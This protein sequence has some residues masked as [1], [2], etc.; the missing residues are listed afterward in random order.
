MLKSVYRCRCRS[1]VSAGSNPYAAVVDGEFI[2]VGEDGEGELGGPCVASELE[3]GVGVAVDVDGGLFCFDEEFSCAADSEAVVGG[4]C[5]GADFDGVFVDDVFVCFC[6]SGGVVYVPAESDEEWV[7]ELSS[8][9]GFV[10]SAGFV[11]VGV[12]CEALDEVDD[13][14][15]C[16]HFGLVLSFGPFVDS[17]I[18]FVWLGA[19]VGCGGGGA[20]RGCGAAFDGSDG[21]GWRGWRGGCRRGALAC[22]GFPSSRE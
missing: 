5:G 22:A 10:V 18:E 3:C 11:C 21:G 17:I 14:V 20:E 2:E 6:V 1:G 9:L 16:G 12:S 8:E 13:L 15:W 19:S 4:F 7:D